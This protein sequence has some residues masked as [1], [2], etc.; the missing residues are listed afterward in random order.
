MTETIFEKSRPGRETG[1]LPE[2]DVP[3]ANGIIPEEFL[4]KSNSLPE[5]NEVEI[6]RH[7]NELSKKNFGVDNGFYPLG[8]CTMKY[9][10]KISE[11]LAAL[12]GFAGVHPYAKEEDVQGSLQLMYG[13]QEQLKE[14][15]GMHSITLQPAA[16]AHGELTGLMM[17]KAYFKSRKEKRNIILTPDSSHGTNPASAAMCNFETVTIKSNEKGQTDIEDLKA[18]LTGDA[19]A[20]M[21]TI[22]N[23]LGI[24]EEK[25]LEIT[26][27]AHD[28]GSLV[29]MDGANM[30]ALL[31]KARPEDMD[32]D[33]LHLNLHKTFSAPHGCGGPGCGPVAA[34]RELEPFLPVPRI[35]K[36]GNRYFLNRNKPS[37]IGRIKS[38][39]G[40]FQVMIKA[41]TY[42]NA[43]GTDGL[44]KVSKH[45]VLNANYLKEKLKQ[46]FNLKYD[47]LCKHEFVLDDSK[48][49]NHITTL[50]IAKGLLDYNFHPPTIYFPLI[51]EG[52]MMIE[53]TETE[54]K[55]TLDKFAHALIKIKEQ[56]ATA[57]K[58]IKNS[59]YKTP[60]KRLDE[61]QAARK[62]VL[63]FSPG[64]KN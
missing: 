40:N 23:T 28:N 36:T 15:T 51:V 53:P 19:A 12:S 45:A 55:D 42:I 27:L 48:M 46:H 44:K 49:P 4:R 41:C 54:N 5:L 58:I 34:T 63:K 64:L 1:Y 47:Y 18:N 22:P 52:A 10:P 50:D 60:V 17:V 3:E 30:N 59:P 9:N 43:L 32:I 20:I 61:V 62:P 37:S 29:Y 6:I 21:L 31:G 57:P 7:F 35:E 33:I 8:S 13:L 25:I 16:G 2:L 38:F 39:Y 56:A 11:E 24:F 14:I 26:K